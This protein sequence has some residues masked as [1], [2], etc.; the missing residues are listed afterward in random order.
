MYKIMAAIGAA[1]LLALFPVAASAHTYY[2]YHGKD[3][4]YVGSG[5]TWGGIADREC[6]GNRAFLLLG[7]AN[8][9]VVERE[10]A[11]GCNNGIRDWTVGSKVVWSRMCEGSGS[12]YFCNEPVTHTG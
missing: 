7:L 9:N 3:M 4:G 2:Q 12:S 10:D 6:D 8:G 5:H 11:N 1:L